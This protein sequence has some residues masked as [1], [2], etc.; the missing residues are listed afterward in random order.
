MVNIETVL[1]T[2]MGVLATVIVSFLFHKKAVNREMQNHPHYRIIVEKIKR[3]DDYQIEFRVYN[4]RT[5]TID[6]IDLHIYMET[7]I[8]TRNFIGTTKK[9]NNL[10]GKST[11]Y[12]VIGLIKNDALLFNSNYL[13]NQKEYKVDDCDEIELPVRYLIW[14]NSTDTIPI[15]TEFLV[16][17]NGEI[18]IVHIHES[19]QKAVNWVLMETTEEDEQ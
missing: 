17:E 6:N 18:Q 11:D 12:C 1:A 9:I 5:K 2:V 13:K 7:P 14:S 3:D 15:H 10:Y 19:G 4:D 16:T 8:N